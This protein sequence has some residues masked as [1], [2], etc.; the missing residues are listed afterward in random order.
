MMKATQQ[1]A[2]YF[3]NKIFGILSLIS[4]EYEV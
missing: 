1:V 4:G 3:Y 2:Q